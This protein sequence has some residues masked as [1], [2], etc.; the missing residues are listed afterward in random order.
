LKFRQPRRA[1]ED[2]QPGGSHIRIVVRVT[3][4][5]RI[6]LG[7]TRSRPPRSEKGAELAA[8]QRGDCDD[9]YAVDKVL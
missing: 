2:L 5:V 6:I 8:K 9:Q 3:K 4:A 7:I 1:A